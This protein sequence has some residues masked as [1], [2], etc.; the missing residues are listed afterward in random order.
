LEASAGKAGAAVALLRRVVRNDPAQ[1][2]AGLNLAFL[3]CAVGQKQQAAERLATVRRFSP[4]D[5]MLRRFLST[6][7]YAG[8]R[9]DV[10]AG[11]GGR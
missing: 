1:V 4:D 9:C 2:A 7:E 3:E 5:A 11:A 6:G 10:K 8:Q